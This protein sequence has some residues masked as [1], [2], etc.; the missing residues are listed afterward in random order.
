M[1]AND[2]SGFSFHKVSSGCYKV[3]YTT[4][5]RGDYWIAEVNDM[6]LIDATLNTHW[7]RKRD[8]ERLRDYVKKNGYHFSIYGQRI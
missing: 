2:L 6:T 5:K 8:I 7:A 1:R 4:P 3:F